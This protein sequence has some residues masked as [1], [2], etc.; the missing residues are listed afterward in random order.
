MSVYPYMYMSMWF[1]GRPEGDAEFLETDLQLTVNFL[2]W[3]LRPELQSFV[4][5]VKS[6][7][8]WA[9]L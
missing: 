4:T 5:A 3:M 7:K 9:S 8:C 6:S 2:T 1:S